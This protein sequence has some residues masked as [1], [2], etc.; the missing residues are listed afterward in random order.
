MRLSFKL[1]KILLVD[2]DVLS[3]H[4]TKR[5]LENSRIAEEVSMVSEGKAA[6]NYLLNPHKKFPELIFLDISMPV[7]D[8]LVFLKKFSNT[9]TTARNITRVIVLSQFFREDDIREIAVFDEVIG[10]MPKPLT[11]EKIEQAYHYYSIKM[12]KVKS[13]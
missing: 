11:L 6:L 12:N 10:Y 3:N 8:G 5:L 13:E 7:M 9:K 2:D 4:L 1:N